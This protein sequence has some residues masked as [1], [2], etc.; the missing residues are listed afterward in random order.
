VLRGGNSFDCAILD[1]QMPEMDGLELAARARALPTGEN[2]PLVMLTS[3]SQHDY[4]PVMEHFVGLLTKPVKASRL[5]NVLLVA[6]TTQEPLVRNDYPVRSEAIPSAPAI[7][8]RVLI[9]EDNHVNQRVAM[10]SLERLGLRADVVANGIEAFESVASVD[11]DIVLMDIHMPEVDGLEATQRIR[12]NA[13]LH[14]PYII[15]LTANATV[16]DRKACLEAGMNDYLSKPFRLSDLQEALARYGVVTS[17]L[18]AKAA[19]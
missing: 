3:L 7:S 17:Q 18:A 13:E 14:Q 6:L 15:A 4:K 10:L 2:L 11:Y 8:L 19:T 12:A 1:M 9:A 5:Y 16:E